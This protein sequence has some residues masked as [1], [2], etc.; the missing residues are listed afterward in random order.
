MYY[1]F[2][3]YKLHVFI[4]KFLKRGVITGLSDSRNV[5]SI[6]VLI[7]IYNNNLIIIIVEKYYY[8]L[9]KFNSKKIY[10]I[11]II[12]RFAQHPYI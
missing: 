6:T 9:S 7:I 1:K 5:A 3:Q 12:V 11:Q 4:K 10:I 2:F 8:S